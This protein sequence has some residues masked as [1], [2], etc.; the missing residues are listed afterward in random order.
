[1]S[2]PVSVPTPGRIVHVH[3]KT[4]PRVVP[5]V[6]L[7]LQASPRHG[8]LAVEAV[9]FDVHIAAGAVGYLDDIAPSHLS[10]SIL[11]HRSEHDHLV[12]GPC[13]WDWPEITR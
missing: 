3:N 11:P 13:F 12:H 7:V 8:A 9:V 5:L 6:G 4:A 2:P 1:M 10:G